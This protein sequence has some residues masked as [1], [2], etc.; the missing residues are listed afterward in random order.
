[1]DLQQIFQEIDN[2][3]GGLPRPE[4][5]LNSPDHCEECGEHE[6]T[7]QSVTPETVSMKEV[8][9]PSWDPM[10]YVSDETYQYFMPGLARLALG[11]GDDYF[12]TQLLFQLEHR[13]CSLSPEQKI[14]L[15]KLLNH[16]FETMPEEIETN[17]DEE[18][19]FDVMGKLKDDNPY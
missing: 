18:Y 5:L 6:Q 1:M 19:F 12:L 16:L 10:C 8:G 17:M 14:V 9:N 11:K 15:W 3:F 13:A 2:V 7:L 4:P